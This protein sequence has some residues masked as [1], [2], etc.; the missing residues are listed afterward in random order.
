MPTLQK[1]G[2]FEV[3]KLRSAREVVDAK[4]TRENSRAFPCE[5]RKFFNTRLLPS[6]PLLNERAEPSRSFGVSLA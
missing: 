6:G 4:H 1:Q 2:I 3:F 5:L